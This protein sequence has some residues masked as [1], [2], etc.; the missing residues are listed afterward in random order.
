MA[1]YPWDPM[2]A[3]H[4]GRP[5]VEPPPRLTPQPFA[6][7]VYDPNTGQWAT[8]TVPGALSYD[9][10][11]NAQV[12]G[13]VG[14]GGESALA[15]P[16]GPAS[17]IP[18]VVTAIQEDQPLRELP[19]P[20][21]DYNGPVV[22]DYGEGVSAEFTPPSAAASAAW[23]AEHQGYQG[24]AYR[25]ME[26]DKVQSA[27]IPGQSILGRGGLTGMEREGLANARRYLDQKYGP[28]IQPFDADA[29]RKQD[30]EEQIA[31]AKRKGD[32]A[33]SEQRAKGPVEFARQQAMIE[34]GA[35]IAAQLMGGATAA[36]I[37]ANNNKAEKEALRADVR[38]W[39]AQAAVKMAG[40]Q[41]TPEQQAKEQ[42]TFEATFGER[43]AHL[44]QSDAMLSATI[45]AMS[46]AGSGYYPKYMPQPAPETTGY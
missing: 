40:K 45:G 36:Q 42:A 5:P 8:G 13:G 23:A 44:K 37:I 27:E 34:P 17:F 38:A 19:P 6:E 15:P 1:G 9:P 30:E 2:Q 35:K 4:A 31:A 39:Q 20:P 41:P 22:A 24:P 7:P 46:G 26:L 16:T 29:A 21:R 11:W 43:V 25:G 12:G 18:G 10:A 3:A 32:L 33:L 28:E 14:G